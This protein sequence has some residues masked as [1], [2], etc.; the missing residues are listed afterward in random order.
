MGECSHHEY[1]LKSNWIETLGITT[2]K[3]LGTK[4]CLGT[5]VM[6]IHH[7][8]WLYNKSLALSDKK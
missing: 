2:T 5:F 7:L 8:P 6:Y 1:S 4:L 3:V